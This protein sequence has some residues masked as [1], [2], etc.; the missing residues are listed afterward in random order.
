MISSKYIVLGGG[1]V[2]G[3]AAE[4]L[5][6]HGLGSG[7]LLII[8][9]DDPCRTNVHLFPRASFRARRTKREF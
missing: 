6:S 4:E 7:E 1:M 3:Y 8:S 9:A 5:A 2:A